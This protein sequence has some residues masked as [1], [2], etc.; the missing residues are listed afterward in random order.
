M[1]PTR[2]LEESNRFCVKFE[3][4]MKDAH[5]ELLHMGVIRKKLLVFEEK[6]QTAPYH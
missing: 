5:E 2:P 4:I 6:R 3:N 1:I